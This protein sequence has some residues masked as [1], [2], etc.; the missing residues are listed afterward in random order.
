MNIPATD[1][2]VYPRNNGDYVQIIITK[3]T[4]RIYLTEALRIGLWTTSDMYYS[5]DVR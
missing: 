2:S 5:K 4:G 3:N 1:V